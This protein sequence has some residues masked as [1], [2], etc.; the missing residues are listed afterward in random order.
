[1]SWIIWLKPSPLLFWQFCPQGAHPAI[2]PASASTGRVASSTEWALPWLPL[3]LKTNFWLLIPK[4]Q[5]PVTWPRALLCLPSTSPASPSLEGSKPAPPGT[6]SLTAPFLRPHA[7][8]FRLLSVFQEGAPSHSLNALL[9]PPPAQPRAS[10]LWD[11]CLLLPEVILLILFVCV[12]VDS[13]PAKETPWGWTAEV[14]V[15]CILGS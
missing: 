15:P 3:A 10:H 9:G 14:R 8:L 11:H 5:F 6:L 4:P 13:P 12:S 2:S 1:M 7:A